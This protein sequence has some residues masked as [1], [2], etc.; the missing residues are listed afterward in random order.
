MEAYTGSSRSSANI[1]FNEFP[2]A[3]FPSEIFASYRQQ[4]WWNRRK[5][6]MLETAF[7]LSSSGCKKRNYVCP[8]KAMWAGGL[9]KQM[10]VA[11]VASVIAAG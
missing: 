6:H 4:I 10:T 8:G 3:K 9:A 7:T 5:L 11:D 1:V 2:S